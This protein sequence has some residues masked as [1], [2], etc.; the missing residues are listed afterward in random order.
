MVGRKN[1]KKPHDLSEALRL[2]EERF[3]SLIGLSSDWYW[4]QDD[5]YRFTVITGGD[6]EA[7]GVDPK[8][9][10]GTARWDNDA[11]PAGDGGSWDK[12]K[13]VLKARRP[14]SDFVYQRPDSKGELHYFSVS[15]LPVFD[16]K[17]RFRGY[18]GVTRDVTKEKREE[19]LLRLEHTVTRSLAEADSVSGALKAVI[20]AICETEGW[21]CGRYFR[22][23]NT[24]GLRVSEDWGVQ[25]AA[26]QR[27]L[28]R[29][30]E[31]SY[32][33]GVG[34]MGL[35]WQSGQPEWSS[36]VAEDA[37]LKTERKTLAREFG[38]HGAFHFPVIS[39]GKTIGVLGFNSYQVR[40]PEERLLQAIRAIGSQIS[41]FVQRKQTED[42]VRESEERF[43]SLTQLSSD[44]YWEQDEQYRFTSISGADSQRINVRSFQFIGKKYW[45]QNYVNMTAD[46][47][48]AHIKGM[49]EQSPML[50]RAYAN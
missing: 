42:T 13:A 31:V 48:A 7:A 38:V 39:E 47:W 16:E 15:G 29:S 44:M 17:G 12:H 8:R 24:G 18:R 27:F 46:Y 33:P 14:F 25:S 36:D 34:I 9:V 45:E 21:D 26:I 22:P 49:S 28:T 2:A 37:R 50:T 32:G 11:V 20:R 23:D 10:L 5:S 19:L 1:P 3:E 6:L 35:A 43:R 40:E 41:Q 4:E 30:R